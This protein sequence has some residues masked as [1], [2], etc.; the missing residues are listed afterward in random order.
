VAL[1]VGAIVFVVGFAAITRL[2]VV[3][4]FMHDDYEY[5]YPSFSL[6]RMGEFGSP[7][8]GT[9]L[10]VEHRTYNFTM[11]YYATVHAAL[12]RMYG[13]RPESMALANLFHGS[14]LL[15]CAIAYCI[16]RGQIVM[17]LVF[18]IAFVS[19]RLVIAAALAGRPEMTAAFGYFIALLALYEW[20][21]W[22][23]RSPWLL[24][25]ASGGAVVT[26]LT[27]PAGVIVLLP[28][29]VLFVALNFRRLLT[30]PNGI[31]LLAPFAVPVLLYA[32]FA[33]T[34][35]W[36][37]IA[38]Q[39]LANS[40]GNI[41]WA[42]RRA[43]L[44]AGQFR[45]LVATARPVWEH[46]S[47]VHFAYAVPGVVAGV[48]AVAAGDRLT[49]LRE[50]LRAHVNGVLFCSVAFVMSFVMHWWFLKEFVGSY[51]VIYRCAWYLAVGISI[52]MLVLPI[53][54]WLAAR[55]WTE[56]N[57]G[58]LA[59]A[60]A[61][62]VTSHDAAAVA[63]RLHGGFKFADYARFRTELNE[64]MTA[65]GAHAGDHIYCPSPFGT[66]L[67]PEF[68]PVTY[69]GERYFAGMWPQS[70]DI[71]LDGKRAVARE[72]SSF[73]YLKK[74]VFLNPKWI[75]TW[76]EDYSD[77][78][79]YMRF[80]KS[81]PNIDPDIHIVEAGN[82]VSQQTYLGGIHIFRVDLS[83]KFSSSLD[84]T[85]DVARGLARYRW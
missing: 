55:H 29:F 7:L 60:V 77:L 65:A 35:D 8:M 63:A 68:R 47:N 80:V 41:I 28:T 53:Q 73:E 5:T 3:P 56:L 51:T 9:G 21:V 78:Q 62:Y 76:D 74:I 33:A 23:R 70:F 2:G 38:A 15:A 61:L 42:R 81:F 26:G 13:D 59:L 75:V 20:Q 22:H 37:N 1:A 10:N 66:Y 24:A 46:F 18:V 83:P 48:A 6:A 58:A 19:D 54:A 84:R 44:E 45:E 32:Y 79:D 64:A 85:L 34:D 71:A 43:M 72:P 57:A 4:Q 50:E 27:H 82:Y 12:I 30:L 40:G 49:S 39:M 25:A 67:S 31:A 16:Y 11:Y 14:L 36:R 52:S 69:G 17:G